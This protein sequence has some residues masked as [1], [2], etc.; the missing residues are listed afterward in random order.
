MRIIILFLT[1]LLWCSNLQADSLVPPGTDNDSLKTAPTSWW[2][3]DPESN[4]VP[5]INV[6]KAYE[7]LEGRSSNTV[8]VAVIDSGID[9]DHEDLKDVIWTNSGEIEG[10][11]L[12]DDNNGYIDDVHGWNFLGNEKGESIEHD[13]YELTREFV[14]LQEKFSVMNEAQQRADEEW[15]Y[16][17][18]IE[19]EYHNTVQKMED[20]YT[21]FKGFYEQYKKAERLLQAYTEVEDLTTDDLISWESPDERI[22]MARDIMMT[23]FDNGLNSEQMDQGIEYFTTALEYGYNQEFNPRQVIGD[24]IEDPYEKGYG[25]NDVI[26]KFNMHGT[27]VAGIIGASRYND[28]GVQGVADNV[29]IMVLRAIPNGDE[30][31]KDVA[32]AI[33]YAV[34]NGAQIINM[35]FGKRFSPNKHV[36]DEAMKNAESKGVLLIHA[37]GNSAHN[38]DE[39]IHYPSEKITA[40]GSRV[41]N[42]LVVGAADWKGGS[43]LAASFSNFGKTSVDVF[44]PGV[45]ILSASPDQEYEEA[46]GTSMAAPVTTGIAALVM[47]YF[48]GLSAVEVKDILL[49]SVINY[50]NQK[51]TIPGKEEETK[52]GELS[53]TGG[54]VNAYEAVKLAQKSR[55]KGK[56]LKRE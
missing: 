39:V 41:N 28:K 54:V 21:G 26:G 48:P 23:A 9:I 47:S 40:T 31:D 36:V 29:R 1:G 5:G 17:A 53:V 51:V 20:Q 18:K 42:M 10:N 19:K 50:K 24:N 2:M 37:A 12:D 44:A 45:D 22:T 6:E 27:H 38:N 7:F 15:D 43:S 49:K 56:K 33:N 32:N 46:S 11:G 35:S 55:P 14:R 4:G 30:R 13:S 3:L 25:N 34:A 16:Y 8:V 52:F